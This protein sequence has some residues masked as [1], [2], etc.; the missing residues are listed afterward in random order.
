[1]TVKTMQK[2]SHTNLIFAR[3]VSLSSAASVCTSLIRSSADCCI[4][5][6]SSACSAISA[7]YFNSWSSNLL[8]SSATVLAWETSRAFFSSSSFRSCYTVM[9]NVIKCVY[10]HIYVVRV[11]LTTERLWVWLLTVMLSGNGSQQVVHTCASDTKQYNLVS[12][13]WQWC[14][15]CR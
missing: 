12:A 8:S 9:N 15:A 7:L 4:W 5:L 6:I 13:R 3:R 10:S 1:M 2:P 11:S 14:W